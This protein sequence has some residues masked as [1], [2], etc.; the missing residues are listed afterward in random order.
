MKRSFILMGVVFGLVGLSSARGQT[1]LPGVS[2]NIMNAGGGSIL[3][4]T[5]YYDFS[6]G[7]ISLVSTVYDTTSVSG[8]PDTIII[9]QGLLQNDISFPASVPNTPLSRNLS[10]FPNP[11]RTV[12][13]LQYSSSGGGT[14]SYRLMDIN[15]R[16]I[17]VNS[18]NVQVG[19]TKEQI[20]VSKLAAAT[21]M[22]EVTFRSETN[23]EQTTT[24][25]IQKLQ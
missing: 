10:V 11:A 20:N 18:A 15:S 23:E 22:L 21:Y 16:V 5:T 13:N 19:T 25:K 24:Y 8:T 2:P 3:I 12:V 1:V 4:G 6:I 9:T 7:E 17:S 14:L